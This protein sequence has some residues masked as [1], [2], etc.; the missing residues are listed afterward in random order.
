MLKRQQMKNINIPMT[1]VSTLLLSANAA[2]AQEFSFF[3]DASIHARTHVGGTLERLGVETDY[4]RSYLRFEGVV[5]FDVKYN[6]FTISPRVASHGYNTAITSDAPE[7]ENELLPYIDVSFNQWTF[8]FGDVQGRPLPVPE[9]IQQ[10]TTIEARPIYA[11]NGNRHDGQVENFAPISG[12]YDNS[13]QSSSGKIAVAYDAKT[14][15]AR[16]IYD[17]GIFEDYDEV[18][19][20]DVSREYLRL[21]AGLEKVVNDSVTLKFGAAF[22]DQDSY[23]NSSG[24]IVDP[25]LGTKAGR[26]GN[27]AQGVELGVVADFG[28]LDIGISATHINGPYS[29]SIAQSAPN[30]DRDAYHVTAS[31]KFNDAWSVAGAYSSYTWELSATNV[32]EVDGQLFQVGV[33][34]KPMK[35][36]AVGVGYVWGDSTGTN[37]GGVVPSNINS[38]TLGVQVDF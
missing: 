35:H 5:G 34:W 18:S 27:G 17:I 31:Y 13:R 26:W 10:H 2:T 38:P 19:N 25:V 29:N 37:P 16:A 22:W 1:V 6:N 28:K 36:V 33:E 30:D 7:K 4:K 11:I 21:E 3:S 14:W 8:S 23:E 9:G 15:F 20:V 12:Y 32:P 24:R